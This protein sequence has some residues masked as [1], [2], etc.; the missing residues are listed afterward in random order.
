MRKFLAAGLTVMAASAM[1]QTIEEAKQHLYYDRLQSAEQVLQQVIQ[2]NNEEKEAYY[3]LTEVYLETDNVAKAKS[4]LDPNEGSIVSAHPLNRVAYG[5]IL[6]SENKLTEARAQFEAALKETKKKDLE[7]LKAIARAQVE[8]TGGDASY[9]LAVLAEIKEKK[10]DA[11]TIT[12][13]GDAHR[14]LVQGSEAAKSY[15]E[16]LI[17]NEKFAEAAYKLGKIYMT[18]QNTD[19]FIKYFNQAIESDP[20]YAAAYYEL[21]YYYYFR[22]VNKAKEYL[23]LY[24]THTDPSIEHQYMKTDLAYASGKYPEAISGANAI[25]E[26][27]GDKAKP[28]LYK[29]LAYSYDGSGDSTRAFDFLNTYFAKEVDSNIVAKDFDLKAKLLSKMN[30]DSLAIL[31]WE[32]AVAKDTVAKYRLEYMQQAAQ[33]QKKNKNRSGEAYW[34]GKIYQAKEDPSNLDIYNWGL[35]HYA[36]AEFPAADSVFGLYTSKYPDQVYGFYWR[37]RS[38]AQIDTTMEQ[39]LAIADY[40]KVAEIAEADKEK[41]KSLLIQAYGYLGA[42]EAN[43]KKDYTTALGWFEKILALQPENSDAQR[44]AEILK[45]WVAEGK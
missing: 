19:M 14:K 33:L 16:A 37:A 15:M 9:A 29:L 30:Q 20:K 27:E 28:R 25:L 17:L 24:I 8:N 3:W 45:K 40:Q 21:Y 32:Q 41:N 18:Q 5:S 39:G 10:R 4:L 7:V 23:D 36:A 11:E 1:G 12:L 6:L 43:V 2:Q 34:L 44:F 22:D 42:Y 38:R 35:A 31:A 26:Q 13:I